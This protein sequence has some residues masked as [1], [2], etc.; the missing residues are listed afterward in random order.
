M[1]YF[2]KKFGIPV[3]KV[4]TGMMCQY[5]YAKL[6][7]PYCLPVPVLPYRYCSSRADVYMQGGDKAN[8]DNYRSIS[9][10]SQ[11][12]DIFEKLIHK[13]LSAFLK[14]NNLMNQNQFGFQKGHSTAHAIT[15]LNEHLII[16]REKQRV[17]ALLFIDLKSAFDTVD[18]D[19]NSKT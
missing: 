12:N 8:C 11:L 14:E 13:K 6:P 2:D 5:W 7:V 16:N 17:S 15:T 18:P 3:L 9:V 1:Q 10:L 19:F 4:K